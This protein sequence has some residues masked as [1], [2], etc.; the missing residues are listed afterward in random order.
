MEHPYKTYI[1]VPYSTENVDTEKVS[2]DIFRER[3]DAAF[4]RYLL[5]VSKRNKQQ[6]P[7]ELYEKIKNGN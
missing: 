4:K 2:S 6:I 1:V 7:Q 3:L 5:G